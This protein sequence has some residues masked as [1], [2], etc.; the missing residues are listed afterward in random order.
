[1]PDLSSIHPAFAL[2]ARLRAGEALIGGWF[3]PPEAEFAAMVAGGAVDAV[4]LD[5]QHGQHDLR[6]VIGCVAAIAGAGK[7]ALVRLAVGDFAMAARALDVGAVGVIAPMIDSAADA[8]AFVTQVKY[9]PR[10]RRSWG[11]GTAMSLLGVAEPADYLHG[12]ND[13]TLAL[14]MIETREA[15]EAIDEILAVE[16][17]DGVFVGPNDLCI[18]LTDGDRAD[19]RDPI[20][21]GALDRIVAAT[22]AAGKIAG[23]FGGPAERARAFR[24]KGFGF[25]TVGFDAMY[26]AAGV[27]AL[28]AEMGAAPR[29][30]GSGPTGY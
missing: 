25:V 15:V 2:A 24:A 26:V 10:G 29:A 13:A 18:A 23:I 12:A 4:V 14:A 5:V 6:S 30:A 1:M 21:D 9:P 11:A 3:C 27:A 22:R 19:T 8:R 28:L 16:G 20:L 17:I 7:P